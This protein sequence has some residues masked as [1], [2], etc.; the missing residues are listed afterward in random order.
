[1]TAQGIPRRLFLG[2]AVS[3]IA[4]TGPSR[5][6]H[7]DTAFSN[8]SFPAT[9]APTARTMPDRLSDVINVKDWGAVGNHVANDSPKIQ[10]AIDYCISKG[11][12]TVFFPEGQYSVT[13]PFVVGSDSNPSIGVKFLGTGKHGASIVV[14]H[15]YSDPNNYGAVFS[16]GNKQYD[17]IERIES[18]SIWSCKVTRENVQIVSCG[19]TVDASDA[20][21]A[22]IALCGVSGGTIAPNLTQQGGGGGVAGSF[23]YAVGTG[24]TIIGCRGHATDI[25]YML[26]GEGCT[27]IA[28]SCEGSS[29][30]CR[31][32]WAPSGERPTKG[33]VIMQLQTEQCNVGVDLY[34]LSGGFIGGNVITGTVGTPTPY[35]PIT[36][37]TWSA[38]NGG[39]VTANTP[40]PH[41]IPAGTHQIQ[42]L[43]KSGGQSPP[44][45]DNWQPSGGVALATVTGPNQFQYGNV[46]SNPGGYEGI[47]AWTYPLQYGIRF[48]KVT[49]TVVM[50]NCCNGSNSVVANYDLSY[51]GTS[52][53]NNNTFIAN[54]GSKGGWLMPPASGKAS[55]VFVNCG[56]PGLPQMPYNNQVYGTVGNPHGSMV[57]ANL[58]GQPGVLQDGPYEG[59]E[60]DI[61]DGNSAAFDATQSGGGSGHYKVRWNGSVW[62]R[63]G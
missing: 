41:N 5:T 32:G 15:S 46:P 57:F 40:Q 36:S 10:A 48:K 61:T 25:F 27:L 9:G 24:G 59:Q 49:D 21:G 52:Q 8:F 26:S 58:P 3:A 42:I 13:S 30:A 55:G 44:T 38:V 18:M 43:R 22:Y 33:A 37:M 11:G 28:S 12:G 39:T 20:I 56:V 34:N 7:A 16:K 17:C 50:G 19:G 62:K 29:I 51:D 45:D 53:L 1:M 4:A 31:V 47:L 60:Y 2:S 63:I 6:A 23:G 35:Q 54:D 14:S